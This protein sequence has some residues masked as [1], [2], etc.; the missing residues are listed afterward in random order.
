M[1]S[2]VFDTNVIVSAGISPSG[3]PALLMA[4]WILEGQIQLV[5]CP[6]I[7][8]EYREVTKRA[9][10]KRYGFPPEWHEFV[11]E[12]SLQLH[13]PTVWPLV[14]PDATDT[15]F[16]ALAEVAGVWLV[17]G[18]EKRFPLEIRKQVRVLSPAAYLEALTSC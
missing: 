1:R 3:A 13:E 5:T 15:V 12:E 11:M 17:T 8:N 6:S 4:D 18:N 16:L 7:R 2:V 9:R 10:F 14:G